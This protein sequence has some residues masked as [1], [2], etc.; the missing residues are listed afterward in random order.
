MRVEEPAREGLGTRWLG[1]DKRGAV[2][3]AVG[4]LIAIYFLPTPAPLERAG[5][6]IPLTATGKTC[7]GIMA[8]AVTLWVTEALP[9]AATSLLVVLLIPAFGIA[10][11]RSVVRASFGDP[12]IVFFIGVLILAAAFTISGLGTRLTYLVLLRVGTRTDRVLLGFLIVGALISMWITDIAVAA[13]LLPL[14]V[15]LLNDAGVRPGHSN[16]GRALMIATAF[17][18]LIGGIA[19]PAGTAANLVAIAQLKQLANV[20]VSFLR[21]MGLGVPASLL[22]IPFAW[23]ILLWLFP[24]EIERLP[25]SADA[26]RARLHELGPLRRAESRTL[27]VFG[28]VVALWLFTSLPVEA[29]GLGAGVAMFLPGIRVLSWKEAEA[30]VEWGGVM[31]IVAGLS[32]GLVVFDSGAARWLAWVLLGEITSVPDVLR[33]FVIV[34]AVAGLHMLFSSNTVT[35]TIIIPILVALATDLRLDPWTTVAP[36]AFT[37]SLAFILVSEGPTTIIPYSAGYFSIRDMAKAGILMTIAAAACVAATQWA[38]RTLS[39][40]LRA[41]HDTPA[42][43]IER[44]AAVHDAAVVPEHQVAGAPLVTPRQRGVCGRLPDAIEQRVGLVERQPLEPRVA[45]SPEVEMPPPGFGMN[46]DK[47]MKRPG[48]GPRIVARRDAGADVSAAVVRAVMLDA[49][50][51]RELPQVVRERIPRAIHG[52]EARVASARRDFERMERAR[53]RRIREVRHI[54][55]PDGFARAE[56]AD[57]DAVLDDV[58]DDVDL[59]IAVDE[60]AAVLLDGRLIERPEAAAERDQ[61]GVAQLLIAQQDDSVIEPRLVQSRERRVIDRRRIDAAHFGTE[62]GAGRDDVNSVAQRGHVEYGK[63]PDSARG[64]ERWTLTR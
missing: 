40:D 51:Q 35:A 10:D 7:L 62:C 12:V 16:F 47:G 17:G 32:L 49:Q 2:L 36:A 22:M 45:A 1:G 5:N 48:R 53:F 56:A 18:P 34:L 46:A 38:E 55:M 64:F 31:M 14:A 19:T 9:F 61:I 52:A 39:L 13:M 3:A 58:R 25:I 11:F 33:P 57:G 42:A 37:S 28:V 44:V 27:L 26:I 21:W 54:G 8:F 24:P 29:V 23:R 4:L 6:V 30:H 60:P 43:G 63:I 20:D 50:R 41:V 15:G 59:G